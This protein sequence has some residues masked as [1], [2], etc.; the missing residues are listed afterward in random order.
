VDASTAGNGAALDGAVDD[1]VTVLDSLNRELNGSVPSEGVDDRQPDVPVSTAYAV[2]E[3]SRMLREAAEDGREGT[4]PALLAWRV[5][6]AWNAVLAGDVDS[7]VEYVAGEER[8][9]DH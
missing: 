9:R 6:V 5:D 7:L 3:V 4:D 2:S 8:M 1:F